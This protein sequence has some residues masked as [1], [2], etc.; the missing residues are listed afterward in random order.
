MAWGLEAGARCQV[1]AAARIQVGRRELLDRSGPGL[2]RDCACESVCESVDVDVTV[3]ANGHSRSA[4]GSPALGMR[5]ALWPGS[6]G[7][8]KTGARGWNWALDAAMDGGGLVEVGA[9]VNGSSRRS[10]DRP[11]QR[12][13]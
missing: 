8:D 3:A 2:R 11:G 7:N 5:V 9:E 6:I 10:H 13:G 4:D 1:P 12:V